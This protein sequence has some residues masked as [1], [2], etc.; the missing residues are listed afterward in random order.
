[1]RSF[2]WTAQKV[3]LRA[4]TI[5]SRQNSA[6]RARAP[7]KGMTSTASSPGT[8]SSSRS[9]ATTSAGMRRA[10]AED[11]PRFRADDRLENDRVERRAQRSQHALQLVEIAREDPL[12]KC[13]ALGLEQAVQR[14]LVADQPLRGE[15]PVIGPGK[16]RIGP[17]GELLH[18]VDAAGHARERQ[19]APVADRERDRPG[20]E[21]RLVNPRNI[22]PI[23]AN[24]ICRATEDRVVDAGM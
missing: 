9:T 18:I 3:T 13:D 7:M 5:P 19:R 11:S 6:G 17:P 16:R 12:G 23:Q 2:S 22:I 24:N 8:S 14:L 15:Q 4:P 1:M 21:Q 20:L 10:R